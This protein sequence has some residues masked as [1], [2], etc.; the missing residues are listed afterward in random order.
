MFVMK[1][2]QVN[3]ATMLETN[4][5]KKSPRQLIPLSRGFIVRLFCLQSSCDRL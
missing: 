4:I 3:H 2:C 1:L 5:D